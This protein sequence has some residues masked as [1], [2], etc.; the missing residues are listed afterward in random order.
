MLSALPLK[1]VVES[2]VLSCVIVDALSPDMPIIYANPAFEEMTGY[3]VEEILGQNCRFLQNDD[4]KQD[5]RFLMKEALE[6]GVPSAVKIRNYRR[7]GTPFWNRIHIFPVHSPSGKITHFIGFQRDITTQVEREKELNRSRDRFRGILDSQID[8]VCRYLPDTTLTYVNDA[9]CSHFGFK[10]N[11][12]LGRSFLKMAPADEKE[13]IR[14]RIE[15]VRENPIPEALIVQGFRDDGSPYWIQWVDVGILDDD[16]NLFEIQA[17]GRDVT[18]QM[19]AEQQRLYASQLEIELAKERELADLKERFTSMVSHEFRTPLS[20]IRSSVEILDRYGD[21]LTGAK[22]QRKIDNINSQIARMVDMLNDILA[23]NH[24]NFEETKVAP[25]PVGL[26]HFCDELIERLALVD[27]GQHHLDVSIDHVPDVIMIS[28]NA[29][30]HILTNL[31]TNALKYSPAG[32]TVELRIT[33]RENQIEITV[34]DHGIGIPDQEIGR[35]FDPF[36][37]AANAINFQGTGLGLSIVNQY[38]SACGGKITMESQEG[39]GTTFKVILPASME[40]V[41]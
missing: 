7:D 26:A 24:N 16:G 39:V 30:H 34:R 35:I 9:Y 41:S 1:N 11:E 5:S 20:I 36:H 22:R 21:R 37:R 14:N 4:R 32:S 12:L 28:P 10:R 33:G 27:K 25:K 23:L 19:I 2:S 3:S 18:A 29:L 31:L 13:R 8:L 40:T 17:V 38:V 6:K 15:Q